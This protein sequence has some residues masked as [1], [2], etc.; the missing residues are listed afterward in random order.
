MRIAATTQARAGGGAREDCTM[1]LATLKL[2][3]EALLRDK[4][5]INGAWA[6]ADDGRT[7]PVTNPATGEVIVEVPR[8]GVA[9][10]RRA[11]AGADAAFRTWRR[12]TGKERDAIPGHQPDKRIVVLKEPIGVCA[13][14]TP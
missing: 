8:M 4:A 1:Q 12:K 3:D 5:Y 2:K 6:A 10:T 14:I 9:E 11:I 13:G 7:I